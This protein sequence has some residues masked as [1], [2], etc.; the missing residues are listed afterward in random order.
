[1]RLA[2]RRGMS[3]VVGM[4]VCLAGLGAACSNARPPV[5]GKMCSINSDCEDPLACTFNKCHEACR[6]DGDCPKDYTCAYATHS[7]AD[8]GGPRLKVCVF[9]P[10]VFDSR[11]PFPLVC[12]RDLKCRSQCE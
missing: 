1:M 9:E 2:G 7:E 8:G 6:A 12:G 11:C 3:M 10:C 5:A 4:A